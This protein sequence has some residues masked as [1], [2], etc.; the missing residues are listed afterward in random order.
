VTARG[1]RFA[2]RYRRKDMARVPE[3]GNED[4]E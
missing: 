1:E 3:G 4:A 2:Q